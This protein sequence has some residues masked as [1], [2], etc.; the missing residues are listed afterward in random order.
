[1]KDLILLDLKTDSTQKITPVSDLPAPGI[2]FLDQ[3]KKNRLK[4]RCSQVRFSYMFGSRFRNWAFHTLKSDSMQNVTHPMSTISE[5]WEP[6]SR[7][8]YKDVLYLLFD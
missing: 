8:K 5:V 4:D 7:S 2:E 6:P 3:N 1:M